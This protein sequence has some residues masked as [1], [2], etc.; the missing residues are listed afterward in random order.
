MI[1]H[2][3]TLRPRCPGLAR[4]WAVSLVSSIL[5]VGL[6]HYLILGPT[7]ITRAE[8]GAMIDKAMPR[9]IEARLDRIELSLAR[10]ELSM[11]PPQ[12]TP[13]TPRR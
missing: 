10:I 6:A 13:T 3:A 1:A 4:C 8:A 11:A 2:D 5:L 7:L 9:D 12:G